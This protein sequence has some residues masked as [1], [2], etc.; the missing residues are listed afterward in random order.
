MPLLI[1]AL[2]QAI[3]GLWI[4]MLSVTITTLPT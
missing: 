1:T 3:H 4:L 2:P